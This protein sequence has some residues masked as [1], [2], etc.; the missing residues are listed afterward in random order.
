MEGWDSQVATA[1]FSGPSF[2]FGR[3]LPAPYAI[4]LGEL[5]PNNGLVRRYL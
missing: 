2:E 4:F 3:M 5:Q 1:T